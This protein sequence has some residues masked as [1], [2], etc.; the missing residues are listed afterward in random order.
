MRA[1][2]AAAPCTPHRYALTLRATAL[3]PPAQAVPSDDAPE[4]APAHLARRDALALAAAALASV[5]AADAP[6][7][8]AAGVD[9]GLRRIGRS[10]KFDKID[11]AAYKALPSGLKYYDVVVRCA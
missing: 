9:L 6:P 10:A 11:P 1:R 3:L 7:A 8:D 2:C 5:A 4:A